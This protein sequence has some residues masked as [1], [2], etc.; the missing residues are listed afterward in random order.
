[1][2]CDASHTVLS[3]VDVHGDSAVC[4][5]YYRS[6]VFCS[7]FFVSGARQR[8]GAQS[9]TTIFLKGVPIHLAAFQLRFQMLKKKKKIIIHQMES[10]F[11][12]V[13]FIF[14]AVYYFFY[15]LLYGIGLVFY[16]IGYG[17]Y[18]VIYGLAL[19]LLYFC[20]GYV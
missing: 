8:Q 13:V 5:G 16:Y 19:G 12:P 18:Y 14:K 20:R 1:V 9:G 7:W 11:L 17:L 6:V 15:Y 2:T 10:I 3:F 4:L